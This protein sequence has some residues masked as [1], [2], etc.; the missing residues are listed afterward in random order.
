[1]KTKEVLFLIGETVAVVLVS[2]MVYDRG[3]SAGLASRSVDN[4][5]SESEIAAYVKGF[6]N[7]FAAGKTNGFIFLTNTMRGSLQFDV[8]VK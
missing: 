3:F 4:R 8:P 1:M 7:G 5:R 6:D 2:K